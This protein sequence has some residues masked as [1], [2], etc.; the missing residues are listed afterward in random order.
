MAVSFDFKALGERERYKLMIGTIIPRPIALV[1]TVDEHGRI[2]A[3]PFSFFNCLSADPPILAIGVE[4]NADMSFKDTGHNI[5]MTEVFTV[6]IVSFA[7]AEAM[8][9]CGSKYPRG[10]DELK[11]AGLT[12]VPG[13]KVAS[14]FI[15]EAPAA[16]ECRRHVTLELGRSRQIILGEIVYAHYRDGVVDPER[17]HVDPAAVDAIARLGGDTCATIRDRFEMLTPKL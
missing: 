1:T 2:N 5:R 13:K 4:N 16:F 14:P 12:A 8:H 15:A 3:A 10:V 6:N 11:E 9:V 17:L 7:I